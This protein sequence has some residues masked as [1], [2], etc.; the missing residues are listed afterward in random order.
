MP[1]S[2]I[3]TQ[4]HTHYSMC[5]VYTVH[6][7]FNLETYTCVVRYS[8]NLY[9]DFLCKAYMNTCIL[10]NGEKCNFKLFFANNETI[11]FK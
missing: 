8:S 2:H 4:L 9:A 6:I 7:N 11:L 5:I 10:S 3:Y 1:P